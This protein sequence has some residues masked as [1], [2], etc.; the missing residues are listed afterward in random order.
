M[1]RNKALNELME[2]ILYEPSYTRD[3]LLDQ[4]SEVYYKQFKKANQA[5]YNSQVPWGMSGMDFAD[6][7]ARKAFGYGK[8]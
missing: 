7:I 6:K 3:E 5:E 8:I 2:W 1:K 4:I